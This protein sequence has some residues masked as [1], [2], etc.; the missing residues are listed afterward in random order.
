MH[1]LMNSTVITIFLLMQ[2]GSDCRIRSLVSREAA[3]CTEEDVS[4]SRG[5]LSSVSLT[6]ETERIKRGGWEAATAEPPHHGAPS[7]NV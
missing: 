2:I 3:D 7:Q 5:L 4:A 6:L 1:M